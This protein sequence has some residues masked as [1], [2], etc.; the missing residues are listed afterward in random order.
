MQMALQIIYG[1]FNCGRFY[2][3]AVKSPYVYTDIHTR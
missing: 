2:S 1:S 3:Y